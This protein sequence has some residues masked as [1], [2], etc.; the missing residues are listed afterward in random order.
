MKIEEKASKTIANISTRDIT[1]MKNL[2]SGL[3]ADLE[4]FPNNFNKH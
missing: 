1:K 3:L 2:Q 4:S